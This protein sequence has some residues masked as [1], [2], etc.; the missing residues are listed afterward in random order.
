MRHVHETW[1]TYN[2]TCRMELNVLEQFEVKWFTAFVL[3]IYHFYHE[4]LFS[5]FYEHAEVQGDETSPNQ[6]LVALTSDRGLCGGVHSNVAKAIKAELAEKS[7]IS[8][9]KLV[10]IGDKARTMLQR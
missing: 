2:R 6:L 7:D 1:K 4:I 9:T 5:A 10:L 8:Q 3:Y